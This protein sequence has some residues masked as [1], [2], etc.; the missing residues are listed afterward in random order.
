MALIQELEEFYKK[1]TIVKL[2]WKSQY[3]NAGGHTVWK[4]SEGFGRLGV[5]YANIQGVES[6]HE[7]LAGDQKWING[8]MILNNKT[9]KIKLRITKCA[10]MKTLKNKS[11]YID[12]NGKK[13]EK[14]QDIGFLPESKKN[15]KYYESPIFDVILD[16]VIEVGGFKF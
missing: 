11:Y 9:N 10:N 13:Y 8:F 5:K 1:G 6:K 12:E 16:N 7:G 3:Y 14:T 4:Y 15:P 2:K